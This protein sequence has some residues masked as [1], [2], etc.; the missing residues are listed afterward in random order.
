VREV[1]NCDTLHKLAHGWPLVSALAAADALI[2]EHLDDL[3]AVPL[4]NRL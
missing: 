2:L 3:P 1:G 4:S